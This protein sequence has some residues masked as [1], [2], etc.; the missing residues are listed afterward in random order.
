MFLM[1]VYG[2]KTSSLRLYSH[3]RKDF[4]DEVLPETAVSQ[5]LSFD[6]NDQKKTKCSLL[7]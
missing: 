1:H 3:L 5:N 2:R 7:E 6:C 4:E